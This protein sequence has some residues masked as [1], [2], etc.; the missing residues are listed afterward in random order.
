MY[1]NMLRINIA[2]RI[3]LMGKP[4][5]LQLTLKIS[6]EKEDTAV[7]VREWSKKTDSMCTPNEMKHIY[8]AVKLLLKEPFLILGRRSPEASDVAP[9]QLRRG[10]EGV[11]CVAAAFPE[12]WFLN[13]GASLEVIQIN[14][15]RNT[16]YW[17]LL[18]KGEVFIC[19][20]GKGKVWS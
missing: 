2:H 15:N 6:A 19:V 14:Q 20:S 9:H 5:S 1:I 10:H 18:L 4:Y 3:I 11:E 7:H 17:Q 8:R 13:F 12:W 16:I